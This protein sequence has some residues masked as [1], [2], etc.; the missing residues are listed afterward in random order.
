MGRSKKRCS[1]PG[2]IEVFRLSI[3]HASAWEF[4]QIGDCTLQL[5]TRMLD[6]IELYKVSYWFAR[7]KDNISLIHTSPPENLAQNVVD[8]EK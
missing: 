1:Q 8:G 6:T 2:R 7:T 3:N 5:V 4:K